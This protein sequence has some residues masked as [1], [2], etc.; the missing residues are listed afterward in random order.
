MIRT[1]ISVEPE[2][3]ELFRIIANEQ[4][5]NLTELIQEALKLY[6]HRIS[7]PK[8]KGIGCYRSGRSDVSQK[9]EELIAQSVRDTKN[10]V[11]R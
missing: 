9:A 8:P 2:T 3:M 10:V 7:R 5:R 6:V 4:R 1:T 11:N